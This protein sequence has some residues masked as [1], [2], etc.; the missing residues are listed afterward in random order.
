MRV[1]LLP[2]SQANARPAALPKRTGGGYDERVASGRCSRTLAGDCT[3][4]GADVKRGSDTCHLRLK[5]EH[6]ILRSLSLV[7]MEP[8]ISCTGAFLTS[9]LR[10]SRMHMPRA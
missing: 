7:W 8:W 4:L 3:R 9:S 10:S 5:S 6:P 1:E 2:I